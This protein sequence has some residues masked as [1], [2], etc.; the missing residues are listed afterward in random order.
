M[1]LNNRISIVASGADGIGL[2]KEADATVYLI[3][4]TSEC[5]LIDAGF[6]NT[7]ELICDEIQRD[8]YQL[9]DVKK[10]I[11]TH[12]HADHAGGA[13]EFAK[14][15]GAKVY[16]M[17]STAWAMENA[18]MEFFSVNAAKRAGMFPVDFTLKACIAYPLT[19]GQ[20]I[21]VGDL[22]LNAMATEGH[23]AGHMSYWADIDEVRYL[24]SGDAIFYHGKISVLATTDSNIPA[25]IKT[26]ERLYQLKADALLPG[27][28]CFTLSGADK[29]IGKAMGYVKQLE[30]PKNYNED[31]Y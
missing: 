14:R 30:L 2:T 24:F 17:K 3:N 13:F 7:T 9:S 4:G 11:L 26:I 21:K 1:K 10:I 15:T 23:C 16:A 27:H 31:L 19:D 12:G 18:D 22:C 28:G 5:A 20:Q 29:H 25:Y 8:G 6:G